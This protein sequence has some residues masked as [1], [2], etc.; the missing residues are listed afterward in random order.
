M[1]KTP[2][3]LQKEINKLTRELEYYKLREGFLSYC[4]VV[5]SRENSIK[6]IDENKSNKINS[7][8]RIE[9]YDTDKI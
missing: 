6:L 2:E 4:A 7:Y 8:K 5:K 1:T 9:F 3:Q